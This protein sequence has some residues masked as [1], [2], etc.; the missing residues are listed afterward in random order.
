MVRGAKSATSSTS[1]STP[2]SSIYGKLDQILVRLNDFDSRLKKVE[3]E[4]AEVIKTCKFLSSYY[5]INQLV[6][7]GIFLLII[8]KIATSS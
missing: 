8:S 5:I 4:Q 1:E 7:R 6:T 2:D 3:I